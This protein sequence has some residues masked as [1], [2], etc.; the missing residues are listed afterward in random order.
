MRLVRSG[1]WHGSAKRDPAPAGTPARDGD[2]PAAAA[3]NFCPKNPFRHLVRNDRIS[4]N[5]CF[6]RANL[7]AIVSRNAPV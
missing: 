3:T 6:G 5:V 1:R 4:Y 7:A 2:A